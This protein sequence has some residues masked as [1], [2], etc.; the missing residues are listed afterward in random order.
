MVARILDHLRRPDHPAPGIVAAEDRHD[1]P[2]VGADV[3][4]PPENARRDVENVA[5]FHRDFARIAV[6]APKEPPAALENEKD[7]RRVVVV[8]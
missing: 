5:D 7:L 6:A 3:F 2:V 4:E 8:Q 1:H